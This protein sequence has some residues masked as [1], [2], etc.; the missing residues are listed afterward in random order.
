METK[1]YI[2]DDKKETLRLDKV[3]TLFDSTY[4]RVYYSNLIKNG[5]VLVNKNKVSP[6]YKVKL[7]DVIEVNLEEKESNLDLKPLELKLDVIYE[8]DDILVI[9]KPKGLVVHP[10]DGHHDDTLVNALIYNQKELS[11]VNG[12]KRVGIVHRI[13]KD[14]SGLLLICKNDFVHN[15][16]AKQL[17][18]HSMHREYI[19][20]VD[21]NI[22]CNEGKI[23]GKIGRDPNNRLKMTINNQTGKEAITHFVVKKRFKKYTLIECKLE[24][25]RTHQIRVHM[26]SIGHPI[27]GDKL[28]GGSTYIYDNGQLLHAYKLTF[29]HPILKKEISLTCDI[30]EY[31]KE[32]LDKLE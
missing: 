24:T 22:G 21:G 23:V 31:F 25:G 29:Y 12:L 17:K 7:N 1:T 32:V 11:T 26:S 2:V 16:I 5:D 27:V 18:D 20:L 14:T 3:L 9:N 28:Y 10:G 8:D 6:S 19:A 4:S 15:E 30:P 13:D